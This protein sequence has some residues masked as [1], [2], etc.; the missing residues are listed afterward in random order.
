VLV[1]WWN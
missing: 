1:W